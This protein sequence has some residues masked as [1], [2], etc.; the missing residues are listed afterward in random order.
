MKKNRFE[1]NS[2]TIVIAGLVHEAN[3]AYCLSHGDKS[4]K[5][6]SNIPRYLKD[7]TLDGINNL[8]LNPDTNAEQNHENWV[9]YK[10]EEGWV[11]GLE[12]DEFRKTHPCIVEYGL[13]P[14][15]QQT[16]DHIFR[17]VVFGFLE[18]F[19]TLDEREE[20]KNTLEKQMK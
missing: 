20:L 6:W 7:S 14:I 10:E 11:Y 12:K 1:I 15:Y 16:K 13:L 2:T 4:Q 9:T 3:R 19:L 5:S 8:I 17:S 18:T